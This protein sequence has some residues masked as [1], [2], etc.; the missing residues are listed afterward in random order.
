MPEMRWFSTFE[1]AWMLLEILGLAYVFND[2][3]KKFK[4]P[5]YRT[6]KDIFEKDLV[7][8]LEEEKRQK[9]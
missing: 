8:L 3:Y 2:L 4:P 6:T 7:N 1:L 9:N 5:I